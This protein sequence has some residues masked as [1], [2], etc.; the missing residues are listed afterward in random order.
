MF[1]DILGTPGHEHDGDALEAG[2]ALDVAEDIEAV[3]LR[4]VVVQQHQGR[5]MAMHQANGFFPVLCLQNLHRALEHA[6]HMGTHRLTVIDDEDFGLGTHR[7][8]A[9]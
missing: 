8:D 4:H 3:H 1:E 2:I 9:V 5:R 7:A 6:A